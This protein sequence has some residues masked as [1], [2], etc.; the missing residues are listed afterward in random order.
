MKEILDVAEKLIDWYWEFGPRREGVLASAAWIDELYSTAARLRNA[1]HI[2]DASRAV[3]AVWGPS[4]TGKSTLIAAI[5]DDHIKATSALCW[6]SQP[7]ARFSTAVGA[8]EKELPITLNP[9]NGASD[10]SGC[11]TRFQVRSSSELVD[12]AHPVGLKFASDN[13]LMHALA[14]GFLSEARLTGPDGRKVRFDEEILKQLPDAGG[15]PTPPSP[16]L[17][18][19]VH[20]FVNVVD[21]LIRTGRDRYAELGAQDQWNKRLRRQILG[22][23]RL[24]SDE[25]T[26]DKFA[27]HVLWDDSPGITELFQKLRAFLAKMR[28][29]TKDSDVFCSLQAAAVILDIGAYEKVN[30]ANS[31]DDRRVA[32]IIEK[33][34][35]SQR[36]AH[37]L[38]DTD[39]GGTKLGTLA[40][41]G[42]FQGIV[43]EITVPL[44]RDFF[45]ERANSNPAIKQFLRFSANSDLVDFP[46]VSNEHAQAKENLIEPDKVSDAD[47]RL[48]T[49]LLKR[50]KTSSIVTDYAEALAIDAFL[51]LVK[52]KQSV[53]TPTQLSE[54]IKTWWRAADA[55]FLPGGGQ[56]PPLPLHLGITYFN[57]II[58]DVAV[59]RSQGDPL[60]GITK[61]VIQ[62]GDLARS[63][64]LNAAFALSYPTLPEGSIAT[65]PD[66]WDQIVTSIYADPRVRSI[67][68]DGAAVKASLDADGGV[69]FL[70]EKLAQV[71]SAQRQ[72]RA[73]E[74]VRQCHRSLERLLSGIVP[75]PLRGTG[76]HRVFGLFREAVHRSIAKSQRRQILRRCGDIG[77]LIRQLCMVDV[78][79]MS[80]MP[81][82]V[83]RDQ[84][85][86]ELEDYIDAQFSVW[87]KSKADLDFSGLLEPDDAHTFVSH[88]GQITLA[89]RRDMLIDWC[90]RRFGSIMEAAVARQ[91]RMYVAAKLSDTLLFGAEKPPKKYDVAAGNLATAR[92]HLIYINDGT[93]R[94]PRNG[95]DD[96]HLFDILKYLSPDY[97]SVIAPF[98]KNLE[99]LAA[100]PALRR[101]AQIGDEE[102]KSL[103]AEFQNIARP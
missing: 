67:F 82:R 45:D 84:I 17:F 40:E 101:K 24:L 90:R 22:N 102:A 13:Q 53:G 37:V 95:E 15:Q 50:G 97:G 65:P 48:L 34:S 36:G 72:A 58:D 30:R 42:L 89:R 70:F 92:R 61:S 91:V 96:E 2:V 81:H 20:G 87:A 103:M 80:P 29:R 57:K 26:F 94:L 21:R 12:V 38:I 44:N 33:L 78:D 66:R 7:P 11:V 77:Y 73:V 83:A 6:P 1:D 71:S 41:F 100:G 27:A 49:K 86:E 52:A 99:N 55:D 25:R 88:L 64:H 79:L 46:G 14:A 54:G 43:W 74:M 60:E 32:G 9:Y 19:R 76:D 85:E 28:R 31:A 47:P 62:L 10:A 39:E 8:S 75:E 3:Q 63:E 23:A 5:V 51:L 98:F 18:E 68:S 35:L 56:K 16:E 4:Q 69:A 93:S 59:N